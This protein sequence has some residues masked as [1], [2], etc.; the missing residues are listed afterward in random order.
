MKKNSIS[1]L[2]V[3]IIISLF[4]FSEETK[5]K[6]GIL[7]EEV[8]AEVTMVA[9]GD[10]MLSRTVGK[11]MQQYGYDY[12]FRKTES[13]LRGADITFGNLETSITPGEPVRPYEMSFRADLEAAEALQEAGF[14]IL[15]LANNHVPNFGKKGLLDTFEALYKVGIEYVGAGRNS[16]E[17]NRP[18]IITTKG[19][20]FAFLAY[21]DP[22]VV[23]QVYEAGRVRAGTAFMR[24]EKM[25]EAVRAA[26][27]QA[28]IV[29]VSMHSGREYEEKPNKSQ[30]EFARSAIDAGAEMVIGH[31]PHVVQT[32]EQYKGKYIFYSLGNFVFDQMW[33]FETRAGLALKIFF[34][35]KGV[36]K[37]DFYPTMIYD[38]AQPR[39]MEKDGGKM[40]LQRLRYEE[41]ENLSL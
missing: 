14:S 29:I 8:E 33:S 39:L 17:A 3:L 30:T 9:V 28:D 15:S 38:F 35:K 10:V 2:S 32:M 25:Q 18:V 11:R 4:S 27:V 19:I 7:K 22:D 21:N 1:I 37:I 6:P 34:T 16:E 13:F 20:R 23:P 41:A 24:I 36:K 12:P 31:H 26:R 5:I 40:V